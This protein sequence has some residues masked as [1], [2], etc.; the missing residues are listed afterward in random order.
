MRVVLTRC[1]SAN[2]KVDNKIVG[3]INSGLLL[4]VGFTHLDTIDD[5]K[6]M[7]N[8]VINIRVFDDNNGIMNLSAL[9]LNKE[10]LSISQFTLYGDA[11]NGR[12]PSY[13]QALNGE[14]ARKL[15]NIFNE[16]LKKYLKVETGIFMT[17]MKVESINDGPV[18]ILLESRKK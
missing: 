1:M 14:D 7:V 4:L 8:K 12:R 16:E 2:V 15:Y 18:T 9:D 17:N 3:K 10:I 11:T 6:Y 13:S 5:I